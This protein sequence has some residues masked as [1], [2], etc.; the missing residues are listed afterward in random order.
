MEAE[1]SAEVEVEVEVKVLTES[2]KP[3]RCE[4]D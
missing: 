1:G 3:S 4:D 2:Q